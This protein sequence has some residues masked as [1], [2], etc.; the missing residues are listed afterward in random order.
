MSLAFLLVFSIII[1]GMFLSFFS[2]TSQNIRMR[3][4]STVSLFLFFFFFSFLNFTLFACCCISGHC[5]D[6][7]HANSVVLFLCIDSKILGKDVY[8]CGV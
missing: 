5:S 7:L 1:E 8:F 6:L 4:A 2:L 3:E